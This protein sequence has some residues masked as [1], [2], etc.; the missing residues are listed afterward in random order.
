M[1][2]VARTFASF[3]ILINVAAGSLVASFILGRKLVE[4]TPSLLVLAAAQ[5]GVSA[6]S[7]R[8]R[9]V[10]DAVD[11]LPV[12]LISKGRVRH[13]ALRQARVSEQSLMQQLRNQGVHSVQQM[14]LAVLESGGMISVMQ[15]EKGEVGAAP[16][17]AQ[18]AGV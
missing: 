6:W 13:D 12:V 10:H 7:A 16:R 5:W 2:L 8:S 1:V 9:R 14:R 17:R 4:G 3:D 11:N 15:G 18:G